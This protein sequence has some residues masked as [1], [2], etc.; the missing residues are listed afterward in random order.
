VKKRLDKQKEYAVSLDT[1]E[2]FLQQVKTFCLWCH[3]AW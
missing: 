3:V 2:H 1:V